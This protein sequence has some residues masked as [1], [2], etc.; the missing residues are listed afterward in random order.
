MQLQ[1]NTVPFCFERDFLHLRSAAVRA[2]ELILI[3]VK[4]AVALADVQVPDRRFVMIIPVHAL[5]A[6]GAGAVLIGLRQSASEA[7]DRGPRISGKDWGVRIAESGQY[8]RKEKELIRNRR[9]FV[10]GDSATI[11]DKGPP[12]I[13]LLHPPR[14]ISTIAEILFLCNCQ[15][16]KGLFRGKQSPR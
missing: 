7:I 8:M 4:T 12:L 13:E 5:P 2:E 3:E 9:L 14:C 10:C 1:R 15:R 11:Q 6:A 16:A